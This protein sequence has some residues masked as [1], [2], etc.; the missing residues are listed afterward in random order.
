MKRLWLRL[1][2]M[3]S[4]SPYDTLEEVRQFMGDINLHGPLTRANT[5][6]F[7]NEQ[8]RG[9]NYIS[10]FWGDIDA[11]AQ[12][13]LSDAELKELNS[14]LGVGGIQIIS[15]EEADRIYIG[16]NRIGWLDSSRMPSHIHRTVDGGQTTVCGH[17]PR[18]PE[19]EATAWKITRNIPR[20]K[21]GMSNFCRTCFQKGGKTLPWITA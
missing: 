20:K 6:G 13:P 16:G 2:D 19:Y 5:Y 8:F 15:R 4:Y 1:G 14:K 12:A 9:A 17:T 3:D 18:N 10:L 11:Q 7:Q 21:H